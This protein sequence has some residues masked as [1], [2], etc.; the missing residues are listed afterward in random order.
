MEQARN[1]FRPLRD[2]LEPTGDYRFIDSITRLGCTH[3]PTNTKLRVMSSNAKTA[4]GIVG[5]PLAV[6]DEPGA[7][8]VRGGELMYDALSTAQGK[9]DS[10]LR[11][12]F[13]GTLAPAVSG[14]WHDLV[15]RG[16]HGSTHVTVLQGDDA[17]WDKWPTIRKANPLTAISADFRARL[18][19]ERDEARRDPRLA[20]RFKSYRLNR[21]SPDAATMLLTVE[22]WQRLAKRPVPPADGRPVVGIDLGGGGRVERSRG[23]V[24]EWSCRGYGCRARHSESGGSGAAGPRAHGYLRAPATDGPPDGRGG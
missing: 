22:D 10:R 6:L 18:L 9:P 15:A 7:W 12:L 3:K 13:V 16:S 11:L 5:T 17:T 23:P 1:S 24:A 20:A 4:F 21:P 8:E 2:A 19:E 14:W